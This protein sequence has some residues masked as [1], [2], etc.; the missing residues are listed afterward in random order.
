MNLK[1][2]SPLELAFASIYLQSSRHV[3]CRLPVP[4]DTF[5]H[6]ANTNLTLNLLTSEQCVVICKSNRKAK[7]VLGVTLPRD[8]AR[9]PF[10]AAYTIPNQCAGRRLRTHRQQFRPPHGNNRARSRQLSNLTGIGTFQDFDNKM[11]AA[12][13]HKGRN[14]DAPTKRIQFTHTTFHSHMKGDKVTII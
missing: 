8:P 9:P 11:M 2:I 13:G 6:N 3:C 12:Y 7:H 14:N 5:T 10:R 4:S 1:T